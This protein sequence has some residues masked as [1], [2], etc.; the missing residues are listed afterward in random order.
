MKKTCQQ[1]A[2]LLRVRFVS[3]LVLLL[4]GLESGLSPNARAAVLSWSGASGA[5]ANW[6]DSAN[7]GFA[8]TPAN[9][10]TLIFPGGA[11]RLAN[12]NNI[13]S[14]TLSQIRFVGTSG[15]YSLSGNAI[16]LTNSI[17]VTN[18]AGA[19]TIL[20]DITF[21]STDLTVEVGAGVG[22]T[23][24]DSLG[25]IGGLVKIG[26]GTLIF[27]GST[28]NTYTNKTF[29]NAG[30]LLLNKTPQIDSSL[31]GPLIIGDGIGG[32]NADI[33][34]LANN[35]QLSDSVTP[36]TVNSSG[37]FNLNASANILVRCPEA[38]MSRSAAP[39]QELD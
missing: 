13:S 22:L 24:S 27:S 23:L 39:F 7:W 10:D 14:L 9:G 25:G 26:T 2:H 36:V 17:A 38:E 29:V 8:G 18:S 35:E 32:A 21:G 31:H 6:D 1:I 34:V 11:A 5:S 3:I 30:I 12:V 16:T 19:N 28:P 15:G 37:L 20:A 4:L 33:V